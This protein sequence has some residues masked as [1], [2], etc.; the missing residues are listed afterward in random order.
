M[1]DRDRKIARNNTFRKR[2]STGFIYLPGSRFLDAKGHLLMR[3]FLQDSVIHDAPII[4]KYIKKLE[5][6]QN[7]W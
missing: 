5:L 4:G 1:W 6:Y 2:K 3:S 7:L